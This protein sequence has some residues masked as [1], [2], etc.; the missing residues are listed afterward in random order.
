[1]K[2]TTIPYNKL[3]KL[4][5]QEENL[6]IKESVEQIKTRS[7]KQIKTRSDERIK[8]RSDKRIKTRSDIASK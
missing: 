3:E 8:T 5:G 6:V 2:H 7:D 4:F 1:M